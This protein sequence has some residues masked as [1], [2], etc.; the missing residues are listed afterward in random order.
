[1]SDQVLSAVIAGVISV[2]VNGI[3]LWWDYHEKQLACKTARSLE[4]I[5][6]MDGWAKRSFTAIQN[7]MGGY[8]DDELRKML[9]SIGAVRFKGQGGTELWGLL[10]DS[11]EDL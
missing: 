4:A 7:R 8:S 1:M 6:S 5:L 3:K 10:E 9:T 2:V 11:R